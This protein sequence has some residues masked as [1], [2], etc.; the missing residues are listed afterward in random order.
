LYSG[1]KKSFGFHL[2]ANS[3]LDVFSLAALAL[4]RIRLLISACRSYLDGPTPTPADDGRGGGDVDLFTVG[5]V[6]DTKEAVGLLS[7]AMAA[8]GRGAGDVAVDEDKAGEL[9]EVRESDVS[10]ELRYPL[11]SAGPLSGEA[12]A[13]AG[14]AKLAAAGSSLTRLTPGIASC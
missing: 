7:V 9:D 5:A 12:P 3:S 6:G 4:D 1:S 14:D 11:L 2:V 10:D 8:S 13:G